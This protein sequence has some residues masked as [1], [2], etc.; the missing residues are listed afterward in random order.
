M[1]NLDPS[2]WARRYEDAL[3][4]GVIRSRGESRGRPLQSHMTLDIEAACKAI[5]ER[6]EEVVLVTAQMEAIA[7]TL[8]QRARAHAVDCYKDPHAVLKFAYDGIAIE[9]FVTPMFLTGLAGVGKSRLRIVLRRVL[10]GR[11]MI[12]IDAAHP[13]VP[14]IDFIDGNIGKKTGPSAVLKSLIEEALGIGDMDGKGGAVEECARVIRLSGACLVGAD[15]TQFMAQSASAATLITRTLLSLADL[16][17][18][19][20][21]IGNYSLAWK[22]CK[23]DP[24]ATQRLIRDPVVMVPDLP[25]SLDW[26]NLLTEYQVVLAE[27]LDFKLLTYQVEL[28]NLSAGLK[29]ELVGL[30]VISYRIS[31]HAGGSKVS[32]SHVR[33]AFASASF[34]AARADINA[35]ISNLGQ[36]G[37]LKRGLLCPF[38]GPETQAAITTYSQKLSEARA[39]KVAIATVKASMNREE[40]EA[41]ENLEKAAEPSRASPAQIIKMPKRRKPRT[42]EGMQE[43]AQ[44]FLASLARDPHA[45]T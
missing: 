36:G 3:K 28:W 27:V 26:E 14:L 22:L 17:V 45:K 16:Q 24:E 6:M 19:W 32:W 44:D 11:R 10:S 20:F 37:K 5:Q 43:A 21:V 13:S 42:L 2:I 7:T 4:P 18:P 15:E 39:E 35:L 9:D 33:Q 38:D 12:Q 8:I 41:I 30:L 1:T 31:R 25:G 40:R 34:S 29:R 23:R